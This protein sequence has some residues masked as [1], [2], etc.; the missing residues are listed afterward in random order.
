MPFRLILMIF[1]KYENPLFVLKSL[2]LFD[3]VLDVKWNPY[4]S[5]SFASAC[6]DGRVEIW[7]LAIKNLDP[8]FTLAPSSPT[9]G[10]AMNGRWGAMCW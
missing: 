4:C 3:E 5:T 7:D 10:S 9:S 8:I 6:K 2:D 1:S